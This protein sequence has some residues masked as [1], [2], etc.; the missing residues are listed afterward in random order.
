MPAVTFLE[1]T[2]NN[3]TETSDVSEVSAVQGSTA[4]INASN[5]LILMCAIHGTHPAGCLADVQICSR[6][7]CVRKTKIAF[8]FS[9]LGNKS[10]TDLLPSFLYFNTYGGG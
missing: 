8:L 4:K 3:F 10:W 6:Q 2:F 7:I 5:A 1:V 9:V